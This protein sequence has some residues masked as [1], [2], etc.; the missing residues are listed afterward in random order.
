MTEKKDFTKEDAKAAAKGIVNS[1]PDLRLYI[2]A[3]HDQRVKETKAMIEL[4]AVIQA[5]EN[6]L[7]DEYVVIEI[8]GEEYTLGQ[9]KTDLKKRPDIS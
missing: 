7:A 4:I 9:L 6:A 1:I 5:G 2:K 3:A 8:N